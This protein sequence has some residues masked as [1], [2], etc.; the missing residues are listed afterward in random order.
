MEKY[1]RPTSKLRKCN[2]NR[3]SLSADRISELPDD[4]LVT[5][6][7]QLTMKEAACT[8][9]LS[10]RWKKLWTHTTGTLDFFEGSNVLWSIN[11]FVEMK[12]RH[13]QRVQERSPFVKWVNRILESHNGATIDG[14]RVHFD[15]DSSYKSDI[16]SWIKFALQKGARRF[17]LDLERISRSSEDIYPFPA[18]SLIG[19]PTIN[20]SLAHLQLNYVDVTRELLEYLLSNCPFL[21][22]VSVRCSQ[23]LVGAKVVAASPKLKYLE[24]SD[25]DNMEFL[26]ISSAINLGSLKYAG[27][28]ASLCFRNVPN[29]AD[30]S[31]G[32][33]YCLDIVEKFQEQ[34]IPPSQIEKLKFDMRHI[35][36]E[37]FDTF[38]ELKN[39][40]QL[41]LVVLAWDG[42]GVLPY[43]ILLAKCPMLYRLCVQFEW[44][45]GPIKRKM[46]EKECRLACLK[47]VEMSGFRGS[48]SDMELATFL[49]TNAPYLEKITIDTRYPTHL[50]GTP[51]QALQ[52]ERVTAKERARQYLSPKLSPEVEFLIL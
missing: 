26:E 51:M 49:V 1:L 16:D 43:A 33:K 15:L 28:L 30:V 52:K 23:S 41:E 7:S 2:M 4:I 46:E 44:F 22:F 5:I 14:F 32:G 19:H 17:E 25:C 8:T 12:L 10:H 40:K 27:P 45:E 11:L 48:R 50:S 29:L 35:V 31:F 42:F 21:E 38:P 36:Y 9:I 18:Q 37:R 20:N 13:P 34:I 6:L 3:N 47:L 39:L 24:I